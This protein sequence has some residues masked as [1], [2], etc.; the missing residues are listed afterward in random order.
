MVL[1]T[2]LRLNLTHQTWKPQS[3]ELANWATHSA[4]Q[5][6]THS[7]PVVLDAGGHLIAAE[8]QDGSSN[9]R[10]EIAHAKA[11]GA[12]SLGISSRALMNRAEEQPYFVLAAPPRPSVRDWSPRQVACWSGPIRAT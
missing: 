6:L 2:G 10:F 5:F 12:V 4:C 1:A 9:K 11:F 3:N 8:R 7:R